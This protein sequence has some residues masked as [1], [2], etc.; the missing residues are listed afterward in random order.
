MQQEKGMRL[1]AES[2]FPSGNSKD[3]LIKVLPGDF[4]ISDE[5]NHR[6][7]SLYQCE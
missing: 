7:A 3:E 5:I 6:C 1:L 2:G 4:L